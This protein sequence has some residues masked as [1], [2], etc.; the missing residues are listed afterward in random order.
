[1]PDVS[2]SISD[3]LKQNHRGGAS[4]CIDQCPGGL[5]GVT[6]NATALYPNRIFSLYLLNYIT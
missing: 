6:L 2:A 1:M 3:P 5:Y 4:I